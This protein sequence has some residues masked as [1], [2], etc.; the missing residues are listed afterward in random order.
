MHEGD[1]V[2]LVIGVLEL[3]LL[4]SLSAVVLRRI[5]FPYTIGLVVVGVALAIAENKLDFLESMR[6]IRLTPEVVLYLFIP[7]LIFPAAVRLDLPLLKQNAYPIL[8][9]ALPGLIV[10][11]LLVGGVVGAVTPLPWSTAMLFGALISATDPVAVV[12]LFQELKVPHRL[13]S[14]VEGESLFNDA[15]AV[16]LFGAILSAIG[17]DAGGPKLFAHGA[18]SFVWVSLGGLGVGAVAAGLYGALARVAEDDPLIEIALSMVLAYTTFAVAHHYLGVSGILAVAAAG[19]VGRRLRR[20]HFEQT[21]KAQPYLQAYWSYAEFV[22]NSFIFLFLGVGGDTFL[23]HLR[24]ASPAD[25]RSLACAVVA[26]VVARVLVVYGFIG[27]FNACT[28]GA[29]ID[30]RYQAIIFWGGGMRG[31]LPLVLVLSL[32]ADFAQRPLV[33]DMTAGVVLFTLLVAGTTSG[34]LVRSVRPQ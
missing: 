4:A 1:L 29:R 14:L 31:A 3:L 33:L 5:R 8:L 22:A 13:S 30:W 11:T 32:P 9:L 23:N 16:V 27:L 25:L 12:A 17:S 10:S 28:S 18:V 34:R 15:A 24:G 6:L 2:R 20:R 21:T 7:T 26:V 19:L